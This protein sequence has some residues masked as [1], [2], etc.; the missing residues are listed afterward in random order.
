M[1]PYNVQS[2]ENELGKIASARLISDRSTPFLVKEL[3]SPDLEI[4]PEDHTVYHCGALSA[5]TISGFPASG[6]FVVI[7]RSDA[8]PTTL[9][10]PE[11]LAMPDD[12]TVEAN[13]RYEINVRDGYALCAGWVVSA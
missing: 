10:V 7:F 4:L 5:L 11:D 13:T 6:S 3:S 12:F 1:K 2:F 8:V 9:T